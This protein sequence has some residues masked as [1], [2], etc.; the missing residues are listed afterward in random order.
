IVE[1]SPHLYLDELQDI[2][3][4]RRHLSI[5]T[6]TI[7]RALHRS[8]L[9]LKRVRMN[10]NGSCTAIRMVTTSLLSRLSL[11]MKVR[12]IDVHQSVSAHG[13]SRESGLISHLFLS[14]AN[15]LS[16]N[17]MLYIKIVEGSF[18]SM[19][20]GE[21]IDGLLDRMQPFPLPN[22]VIV[23]DNARIHKDPRVLD[24]IYARYERQFKFD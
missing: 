14:V 4:E 16:L 6:S 5:D 17:G 24:R 11:W 1:H 10:V 18:T 2:L 3:R 21:F 9:T 13:L 22:S 12:S 7:W 23:M 15:A 19:S 8:G 20:F